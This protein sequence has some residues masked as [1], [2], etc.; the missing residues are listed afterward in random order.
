MASI[1]ERL[2]KL[3]NSVHKAH[4]IDDEGVKKMMKLYEIRKKVLEE[5][6]KR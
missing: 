5:H 6:P 1:K 3:I 4:N 2:K